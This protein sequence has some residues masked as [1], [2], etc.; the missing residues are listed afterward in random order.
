MTPAQALASYR[1]SIAQYGETV[2]FTRDAASA[3]VKARVRNYQPAELAGGI[4]QGDRELIV[5]A[6]DLAAPFDTLPPKKG[7]KITIGGKGTTIQSVD[8]TTRKIG[9]TLIAYV[10]QV[11]G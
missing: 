7:D 8:D 5:V 10:I 6:P 9:S 4:I 3:S 2:S 11:R 1:N